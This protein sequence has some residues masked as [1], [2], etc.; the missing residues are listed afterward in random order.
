MKKFITENYSFTITVIDHAKDGKPLHCRNGHE[1]GDIYSCEYGC[2]GGF[3][4]KSIAKPFPLMEAVRSGGD[5][6]NLLVGASKHSGEFI[7][8]DGVVAFRL[9][10]SRNDGTNRWH[11]HRRM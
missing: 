11:S 5:L 4:S 8:P 1:V 10:A 6:S 2:P 7:C 9:E 3:C